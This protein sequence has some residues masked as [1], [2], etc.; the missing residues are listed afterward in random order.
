MKQLNY[1]IV[2]SAKRKT[3]TITVERNRTVMV[4]VPEGT[5]DQEVHQVVEAKCQWILA[6]FAIPKNTRR[7]NT[8]P[9]RKW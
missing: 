5:P 2:R 9:V 1:Q 6:S 3:L 7:G 4:H 8:R